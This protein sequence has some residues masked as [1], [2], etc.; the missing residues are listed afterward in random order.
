M[1][2]WEELWQE[3][4]GKSVCPYVAA[5]RHGCYCTKGQRDDPPDE[6]RRMVC[7]TASL[8]LWCLDGSRYNICVIFQGEGPCSTLSPPPLPPSC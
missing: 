5:D 4:Q 3:S 7:D 2:L 8:Q 1:Q 6:W